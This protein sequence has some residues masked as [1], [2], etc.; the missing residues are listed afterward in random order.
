M[1]EAV[2]GMRELRLDGWVDAS[3]GLR[4]DIKGIDARLNLA[5]KI[6]EHDVLVLHLS[7]KARR[8]EETLTIPI[9]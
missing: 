2:S 9:P 3:V 4:E 5:G 7:H 6:F 8:L 1:S